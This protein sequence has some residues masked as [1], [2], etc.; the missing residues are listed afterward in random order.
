MRRSRKLEQHIAVFGESGSGKTVLLSSFYGAAQERGNIVNAGF[1][2]VAEN[3]SQGTHLSQNYLGMKRSGRVPEPNRFAAKSYAFSVKVKSRAQGRAADDG[4]FDA[5]RMVWH[6]Y[7]GEWFEHDVSGVDEAQRRVDTFRNLLQSDVA[8]LMVDG[9]RL[10]DNDGEEERYLKSLFTN[11]CNGLLLLRDDLLI[12]GKPL[13]SFPRIW[14]VALSKSDLLPDMDV[15]EFKDLLLEKAGDDIEK[16]RDVL[17]GLFASDGA[18]A[19][20]ED[21]VTFSSAK[22]E[23][24]KIEVSE[25]VGLNLVLPFA[26]VFAFERHLRWLQAGRVSRKV[27]LQLLENAEV[28][29]AALGVF[30]NWVAKAVGSSNKVA[31]AVGLLLTAVGPSLAHLAKDLQVKLVDFDTRASAKRD[32]LA[33]VLAG[34][35]RDLVRAEE[36]QILFQS[37]S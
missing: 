7:P 2:L 36:E 6:D 12:D 35:R 18:L 13:D 37:L 23:G 17:G 31:A 4:R 1:N 28:T 27:G 26:C 19:V 25:R 32:G 5:L 3:P 34:F 21:F 20:G 30:G 10:L 11:Y 14:I 15:D 8:F 22:F 16:L 24:T 29:A 9:Q 33:A